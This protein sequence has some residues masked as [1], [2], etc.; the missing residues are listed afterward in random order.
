MFE[1]YS[2]PGLEKVYS[3]AEIE[4][5]DVIKTNGD[6]LRHVKDFKVRSHRPLR[7]IQVILARKV[8]RSAA[9]RTRRSK[10]YG[11][12]KTSCQDSVLS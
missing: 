2:H 10:I 11:S 8:T 3:K 12:R 6:S 5:E 9:R 4:D 1:G 7:D